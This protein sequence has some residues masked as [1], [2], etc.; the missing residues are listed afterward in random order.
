MGRRKGI[1][2]KE[3]VGFVPQIIDKKKSDNKDSKKDKKLI[4]KGDRNEILVK[5]IDKIKKVG[6]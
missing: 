6:R 5:S 1:L 2:I 3:E 4:N